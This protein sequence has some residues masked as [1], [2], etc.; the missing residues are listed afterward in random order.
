VTAG[1]G[2]GQLKV[3]QVS[4]SGKITPAPV[5]QAPDGFVSQVLATEPGPQQV[6]V[7]FN[8]QPVPNSP[9]TVTAVPEG[10]LPNVTVKDLPESK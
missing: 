7:T 1:A 6:H 10:A 5:G 8:D 2:P 4:P 3:A 9:F